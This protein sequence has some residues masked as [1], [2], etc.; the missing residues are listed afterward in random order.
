MKKERT[1]DMLAIARTSFLSFRCQQLGQTRRVLW[2]GSPKPSIDRRWTGLTD[3]Y[4]RVHTGD[5]R[6]LGNAIT[7]AKLTELIGEEVA[8]Q[9]I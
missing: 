4:I 8:A 9:V 3:N 2:E 6:D 5:R 1:A 7:P